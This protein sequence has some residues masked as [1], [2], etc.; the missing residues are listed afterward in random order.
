[1]SRVLARRPP[2]RSRRRLRALRR[3]DLRALKLA[4]VI[5][6]DRLPLGV[7]VERGAAGLTMTVAGR[8]HTAE[9]ELDL[10]TDGARVDVDDP[11]LGVAHEAERVIHVPRVDRARE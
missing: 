4:R 9:R 7:D 6:V 2:S 3:I 11:G 1:M 5:D 10:R 8:L